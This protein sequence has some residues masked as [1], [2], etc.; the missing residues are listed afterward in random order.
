MSDTIELNIP[1]DA[2]TRARQAVIRAIFSEL[3]GHTLTLEQAVKSIEHLMATE[4]QPR[5]MPDD[6]HASGRTRAGNDI[7]S[8]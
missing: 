7:S 4:R 1:A 6:V 3:L 8:I 2:K 5:R